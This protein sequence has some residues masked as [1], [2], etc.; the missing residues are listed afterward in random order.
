MLDL[1]H[2]A[3][4]VAYANKLAEQ[5]FSE[6]QVPHFDPLDGG[7]Y[8]KVLFLLEKPGPMTAT[9]LE[10]KQVGS[11]FISRDNNDP[12]AENIFYFMRQ[13]GISR[14]Q[15]IIWNVVPAWNGT[16]KITQAEH[17]EGVNH[18]RELIAL[19]PKLCAV[20]MVGSK[21]IKA[22]PYL[23]STGL[24]LFCSAHPSPI[25][26]ATNISKW[27]AIPTE[28]AKVGEYLVASSVEV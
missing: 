19:L 22:K 25:V 26:R 1:P 11:G 9:S 4:L 24:A 21:A 20:V 15:T 3:P 23:E 10:G 6:V 28:W 13:A 2:M 7:V 8:A 17:L 12:T 16:R 14:E 18:V 27:E 5:G